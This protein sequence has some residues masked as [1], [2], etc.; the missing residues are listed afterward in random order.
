MINYLVSYCQNKS[1]YKREEMLMCMRD[2]SLVMT[3]SV[4]FFCLPVS[5]YICPSYS[6]FLFVSVSGVARQRLYC[7]SP[8]IIHVSLILISPSLSL[9]DDKNLLFLFFSACFALMLVC[10]AF[11]FCKQ[12]STRICVWFSFEEKNVEQK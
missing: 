10:Y 6:F 9:V 11:S 8:H 7:Y 4:M 12:T 2:D 3:L 1:V 5:S